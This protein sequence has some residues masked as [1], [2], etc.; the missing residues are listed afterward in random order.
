MHVSN[1]TLEQKCAHYE[2]CLKRIF[3]AVN[4][5]DRVPFNTFSKVN[6]I[7]MIDAGLSPYEKDDPFKGA[8]QNEP[9]AGC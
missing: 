5:D 2:D 3:G 1:M 8:D 6:R 4:A 9:T 7:F